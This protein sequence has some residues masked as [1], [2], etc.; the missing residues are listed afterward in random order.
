LE[1]IDAFTIFQAMRD[2]P[3]NG[4]KTTNNPEQAWPEMRGLDF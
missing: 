4:W 1:D 3:D 2:I